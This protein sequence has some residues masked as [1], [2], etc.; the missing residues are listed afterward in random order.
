MRGAV[1]TKTIAF[2]DLAAQQARLRGNIDAAIA[3]VLDHGQY[4]MGPEV[5][6]LESRLA[7]FAG[8]AHVISCSSGTD[9]LLLGLMAK[10]VGP[11]DA[12]IV[13]TF[14]F[15][16]TAEA[17][18]LLGAVPIFAD[19]LPDTLNLDPAAIPLAVQAAAECGLTAKGVIPVE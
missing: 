11:G 19:I 18:A 10:G 1:L 13:P 7:E 17:V 3:K 6:R 14:S 2:I 5:A 9:A 4:I 8:S 15:A 12:I 16:A